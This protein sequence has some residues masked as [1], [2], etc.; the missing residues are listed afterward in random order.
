M[1]RIRRVRKPTRVEP[2]GPAN[3]PSA[4]PHLQAVIES[5]G[6]FTV[7]GSAR[8]LVTAFSATQLLMAMRRDPGELLWPQLRRIDFAV[9]LPQATGKCI[10]DVCG[11]GVVPAAPANEAAEVP[12]RRFAQIQAL[13][14]WGGVICIGYHPSAAGA[15]QNRTQWVALAPRPAESVEDLL[16]R[17]DWSI[18]MAQSTRR[19]IDEVFCPITS[20]PIT[21]C[22]N[23]GSHAS[24]P[25]P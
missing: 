25:H 21:E 9:A 1:I 2:L 8:G 15:S 11:A 6:Q 12:S 17:L 14:A 10:D 22:P 23:H 16:R 7:D 18:A 20:Q 4:F 13:L 19:C 3:V 24:K 5:G